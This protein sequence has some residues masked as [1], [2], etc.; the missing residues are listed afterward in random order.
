MH[1]KEKN[2]MGPMD[3]T[4]HIDRLF[5]LFENCIKRNS[6]SKED[7]GGAA[8]PWAKVRVT[9]TSL[10]FESVTYAHNSLL[11]MEDGQA[12]FGERERERDGR[13]RPKLP[14]A[15]IYLLRP[16]FSSL[17][18]KAPKQPMPPSWSALSFQ[19]T[20][21]KVW[22]PFLPGVEGAREGRRA[23]EMASYSPP[24]YKC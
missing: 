14:G 11:R 4:A 22:L 19:A 1:C 3:S 7:N 10:L 18:L 15:S 5:G 23:V 8:L 17:H 24:Q 6:W 16:L 13:Q 9:D 21:E 20:H 12:L 2:S